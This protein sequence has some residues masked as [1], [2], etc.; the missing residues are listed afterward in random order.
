MLENK[1][2][3]DTSKD[4]L[5]S[6]TKKKFFG[7]LF[8]FSNVQHVRKYIISVLAANVPGYLTHPKKVDAS[9]VN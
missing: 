5:I 3:L 7:N 2:I 6:F 1:I 9:F 8:I 4:G